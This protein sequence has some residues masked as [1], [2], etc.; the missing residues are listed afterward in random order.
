MKNVH[1]IPTDKQSRLG[2]FVDTGN[3]FLR[4]PNDLPRGEN[5]NVYITNSEDI[6]DGY[7]TDGENL[8][9]VISNNFKTL[10]CTDK[11]NNLIKLHE[12]RVKKI[13]LTTDPELIKD[14]VQEIP[15]DFLEWFVNSPSCQYD[16]YKDIAWD[17]I[18]TLKEKPKQ[19][20]IGGYAPG[21]YSCECITCKTEFMG[22]KRAVQ[23]E[24]CAIKTTQEEPKKDYSGLHLRHCYQGEYKDGCKYGKDDCPAKPLEPKQETIEEVAERL[25]D[26]F[27]YEPEFKAGVIYGVIECA[28]WQ[29]EQNKKLYSEKEVLDILYQWSMYKIDIELERLADELPNILPYNEWFE[30]F[31]KK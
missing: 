18:I 4:T 24:P 3:L 19:Y 20:P 17:Q 27:D 16:G 1:L 25:G 12:L 30:Q 9:K 15:N 7:V 6:K 13:I 8:F 28:T 31:K 14:G 5:V 2:R 11:D 21:F 26:M 23:C 29:Q 10:R 22:D